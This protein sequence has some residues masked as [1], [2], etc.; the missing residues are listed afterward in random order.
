MGEYDSAHGVEGT[1]LGGSDEVLVIGVDLGWGCG[2]ASDLPV[3]TIVLPEDAAET[4]GVGDVP[5]TIVDVAVG[6]APAGGGHANG[7]FY[8]FHLWAGGLR[9]WEGERGRLL[10][11]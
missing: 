3:V 8:H 11:V 9:R 1:I 4:E 2:C 10:A 6:W 5:D 7:E